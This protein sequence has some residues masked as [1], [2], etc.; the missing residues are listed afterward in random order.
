MAL[1]SAGTA[2]NHSTGWVTTVA[3]D[4]T[5]AARP[6]S[7]A[8][9]GQR[10]GDPSGASAAQTGASTT[11]VSTRADQYAT[12]ATSGVVGFA[13][14][15][16]VALALATTVP[17]DV[18]VFGILLVGALHVAMEVRYVV[19]RHRTILAGPL[20]V[21]ANG[22]LLAI[23]AMRLVSG[24]SPATARLEVVLL[25]GLLVAAALTRGG[26]TTRRGLVVGAVAAAAAVALAVPGS[27]FLVQA[28]LHNLIPLAF[29]WLW[30]AEVA[31]PVRRR[32][33]RG[34]CVAWAIVVP[35]LLLVGAL[36][37]VLAGGPLEAGSAAATDLAGTAGVAK[38]VA[39]DSLGATW[40]PRLLAAFA[41]AQV[42]HYVT[43][44]WFFPRHAPDA[45][46]EFEAT[47]I[48]H[49]LRG[50]RL[51]L[52]ALAATGAI[53]VLALA[54]YRQGR[55]TYLSLA[56]YHAYLEYPVLVAVAA[57]ALATHRREP[58]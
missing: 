2:T 36:D 57:G 48:G 39:P 3:S 22:V 33:F 8:G 34:A 58:T 50:G 51:P 7:L 24:T 47:P 23:V 9:G 15:T 52:L 16:V 35:A 42:L 14:A 11:S 20:F 54:E 37:G 56:S 6:A 4:P 26:S 38:G 21:A 43:W 25:A 45:T 41:F 28:H 5:A 17:V 46:A 53:V 31:D 27:W 13:I 12:S 49:R 30:A 10:S 29:L 1:R 44:C 32:R 55:T 18:V 40:V 19:G